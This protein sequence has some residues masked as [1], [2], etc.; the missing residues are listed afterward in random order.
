MTEL[1][2]RKV[3]YP[4]EK[5]TFLEF[6]W[7]IYAGD[8]LWVPPL[9]PE[10]KKR[11]DPERGAFLRRGE[12]DFFLAWRKGQPVGRICAGVDPPTNERRGMKECVIG[13]FE[14]IHDHGVAQALFQH[15]EAWARERG[16]EALFGPF[17]LD[18]EDSYGVLIEGRDQPPAL[19]CGH[20]PPYYQELFEGYG[21]QPARGDNLA[22]A[23]QVEGGGAERERLSRLAGRMRVRDWVHIREADFDHL[24]QEI[25][26]LLHLLN[27]SLAHL[28]DHIG[29]ERES[30]GSM[31]TSF[32]QFADPGLILFAEVDGQTVGWF[33]GLPNI[34]EAFHH[35]NG[36]RRPWDYLTLWWHLRKKPES[37]TV[38]SVLVL[39]EF[40]Q[41]GVSLLMFDEMAQ[42]A[43]DRG[44]RW[45]DMSL[46]SEDNPF[47]PALAERM[48][49]EVYKR[50]RVYRLPLKR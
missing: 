29:W 22:Y 11:M 26:R 27:V 44:Y 43:R 8:P 36:L 12:A 47:T 23:I 7:K 39:P 15:A 38:K 42:R 16:L 45:A 48:G 9:I 28:P 19:M 24:D 32:T 6:P 17:N 35:A 37:L 49:A 34:N 4:K 46:T 14:C 30:L 41:T 3:R 31:V 40:W 21:F 5:K 13:F 2:V 10:L 18:Y 20:S 25:D 1:E 50:Y 33:P